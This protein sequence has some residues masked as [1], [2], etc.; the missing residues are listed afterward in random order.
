M[1]QVAWRTASGRV[2]ALTTET[3]DAVNRRNVVEQQTQ[4]MR[5]QHIQLTT[6][7]SVLQSVRADHKQAEQ[8]FASLTK[9]H[10]QCESKFITFEAELNAEKNA[11]G[12]SVWDR[13][14]DVL[15]CR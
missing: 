6:E 15:F 12:Q 13:V 14:W 11:V 3:A 1:M 10:Q 7:V 9:L 4:I 8:K 5:R 2:K